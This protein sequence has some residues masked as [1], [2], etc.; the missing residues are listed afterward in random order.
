LNEIVAF[1]TALSTAQVLDTSAGLLTARGAFGGPVNLAK[2]Q[3]FIGI[4]DPL[5]GNPSGVAF[6]QNVF[7]LYNNWDSLPFVDHRQA[8]ARGERLFNSLPIAI[9]NVGGLS[10]MNGT[11]TTCH[12]SPN[13][14]NHSL[15][16]ALN[17]GTSDYPALPQ[18]DVS[19]LSIYT[20][21]CTGNSTPVRVTDLGRAMITG[22]CADIGNVKGPILRGLAGR[23]P[24]FHNGSAATLRDVVEFYNQRFSLTLSEQQKIDLVAFLQSL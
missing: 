5:G 8:I 15:P 22:N 1:E 21:Q 20:I 7:T 19:G 13:V 11:C 10:D 2:Q 3:F 24:Y 18:L 14:G 12:D 16:V 23:A 17:I 9:T 4:N 6:D